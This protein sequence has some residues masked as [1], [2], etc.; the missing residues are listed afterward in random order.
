MFASIDDL[1]SQLGRP[2][3]P[4]QD[5]VYVAK[6]LHALPHGDTVD[7]E[8]F[9]VERCRGKRV[10]EFGASGRLHDKIRAASK[11]SVGFDRVASEGVLAI[12]LDD[13][14]VASFPVTAYNHVDDLA[15]PWDVIVCGEVIEHLSNPGWFLARVQRQYAGVPVI[16]SVPNAFSGVAATWIRK[17]YENVNRDHVAWY[18]PKTLSV[19]LERAGFMGAEFHWYGGE[20]PT[21]E[22]FVVV[23]E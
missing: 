14:G 11:A 12:D 19:L 20:G 6:M 2:P 13:V 7:R 4:H 18:S 23:T 3:S 5:P 17:G 16:V 1:R 22:G 15:V 21:A 9:I 8:A 10:L